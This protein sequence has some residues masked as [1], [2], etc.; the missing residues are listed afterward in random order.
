M[1]NRASSS[2]IVQS[3]NVQSGNFSVPNSAVRTEWLSVC[4]VF[5]QQAGVPLEGIIVPV[6]VIFV[7]LAIA[8]TA[9]MFFRRQWTFAETRRLHLT[10]KLSGLAQDEEVRQFTLNLLIHTYL[11]PRTTTA[12]TST[13]THTYELLIIMFVYFNGR[14]TA[15][16]PQHKQPPRRAEHTTA[17]TQGGTHNCLQTGQHYV[18]DGLARLNCCHN[19]AHSG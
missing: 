9:T 7:C 17:A 10:M 13:I 14:Q 4:V 15:Q 12:M 5:R 16:S 1:S 19:T 6:V 11:W 18:Q 3:C 2:V 8:V